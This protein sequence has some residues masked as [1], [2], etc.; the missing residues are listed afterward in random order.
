MTKRKT[1]TSTNAKI[2]DALMI[3]EDLHIWANTDRLQALE[4]GAKKTAADDH[5]RMK[6]LRKVI[7]LLEEC[8]R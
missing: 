7:C 6:K 8:V 3:V 4:K 5:R 1:L 2:N